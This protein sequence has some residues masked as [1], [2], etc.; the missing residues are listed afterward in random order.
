[1]VSLCHK[2]LGFVNQLP[3]CTWSRPNISSHSLVLC[4][5]G[6]FDLCLREY[7]AGSCV[8][9]SWWRCSPTFLFSPAPSSSRGSEFV[10]E[11]CSILINNAPF[12]VFQIG[13]FPLDHVAGNGIEVN[14]LGY[15][16]HS[17]VS[18]PLQKVPPVCRNY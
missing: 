12:T 10:L 3:N 5:R 7:C 15:P 18:Q 11:R 17:Q 14:K 6:W 8:Q 16:I 4:F 13:C 1:M 2:L 9:R